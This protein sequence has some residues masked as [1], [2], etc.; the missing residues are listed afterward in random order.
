MP[1]I[2]S[3]EDISSIGNAQVEA[4]D[5]C[6]IH[7]YAML[8]TDYFLVG[9][10]YHKLFLEELVGWMALPCQKH[11]V[12]ATA[13]F[14]KLGSPHKPWEVDSEHRDLLLVFVQ[15]VVEGK[16]HTRYFVGMF[17]RE[18]L[19]WYLAGYLFHSDNYYANCCIG[20]FHNVSE[21]IFHN[22]SEL[23]FHTDGLV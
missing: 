7:L 12:A 9:C 19:F 5:L 1:Q 22:V 4:E 8:N 11:D 3:A 17:A 2:S 20:F 21:L 15:Q 16:L 10:Y 6:W 13:W 18:H 14:H 23:I